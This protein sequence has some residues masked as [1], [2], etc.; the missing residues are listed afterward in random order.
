MS[1]IA[2]RVNWSSHTTDVDPATPLP[3]ILYNDP[4]EGK[5]V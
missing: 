2:F 4:A 3:Y 5:T 1:A